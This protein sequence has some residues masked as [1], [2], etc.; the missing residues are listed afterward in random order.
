MIA[1]WLLQEFEVETEPAVDN[2]PAQKFTVVL[3]WTA[4]RK[5]TDLQDYLDAKRSEFASDVINALD[6]V[7]TIT[8]TLQLLTQQ[9]ILVLLVTVAR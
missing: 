1:I 5:L 8:T 7:S 9:M 4:E 6:V 3:K 2:K